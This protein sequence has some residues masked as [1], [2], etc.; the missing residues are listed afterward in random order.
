[1]SGRTIDKDSSDFYKLAPPNHSRCRSFWVEILNTEF[2][3][4]KIE[5]IPGSISRTRTGLNNFQDL[6]K[7]QE[8]KPTDNM[9]PDE[10]RIQQVGL[11][12][13]LVTDLQAQGV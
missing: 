3:K 7:I 8:Y 6:Q 2:I 11:L 5:E 13:K 1:M 12:T 9:T 4:P 10:R